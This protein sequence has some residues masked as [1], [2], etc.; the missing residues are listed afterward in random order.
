MKIRSVFLGLLHGTDGHTD[1]YGESV[2]LISVTPL[3][4]CQEG[5][6]TFRYHGQDTEFPLRSVL[7]TR[8]LAAC[9]LFQPEHV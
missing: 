8:L 9:Q 5:G 2:R 4:N 1:R 7:H 3:H 6:S